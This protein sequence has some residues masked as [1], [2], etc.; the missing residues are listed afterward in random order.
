M[1]DADRL[2]DL[3][4]L[5]RDQDGPVFAAPWQAHAF[6]MALQLSE[7]GLFTWNEWVEH[8][9]REI[10]EAGNYGDADPGTAY[11]L[12]WLAAL[13]K[14]VAAKSLLSPQELASRKAELAAP[15]AE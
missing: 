5:P 1:A 13:E 4:D 8:L 2:T 10:A 11:Y 7:K 15:K 9:S 3:P 6:A 14:L 12:Q